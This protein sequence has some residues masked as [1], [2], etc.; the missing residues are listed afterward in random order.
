MTTTMMIVFMNT[1]MVVMPM[2][3]TM[4]TLMM[5]TFLVEVTLMIHDDND[6]LI[7]DEDD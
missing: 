5:I 6:A 1:L 2:F 4:V 3:M 7:H